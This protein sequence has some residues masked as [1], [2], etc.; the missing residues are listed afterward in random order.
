[1]RNCFGAGNGA[2]LT[3]VSFLPTCSGARQDNA[4]KAIINN[5]DPP[6]RSR[7]RGRGWAKRPSPSLCHRALGKP[8]A[9]E[10]RR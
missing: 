3:G 2:C 5:N 6:A 4:A 10:I 8:S 9:N 7:R 1:M